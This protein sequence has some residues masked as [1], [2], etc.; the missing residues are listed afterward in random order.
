MPSDMREHATSSETVETAK[1][2]HAEAE[3]RL[4]ESL[5]A[6]YRGEA[7]NG[8]QERPKPPEMS[9]GNGSPDSTD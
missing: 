8:Q 5:A 4:E 6:L 7:T 3:R 2:D 1:K 9:A